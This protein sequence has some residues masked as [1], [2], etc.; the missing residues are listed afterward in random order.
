VIKYDIEEKKRIRRD[1]SGKGKK[2]FTAIQSSK[3]YLE[4]IKKAALSRKEERGFHFVY[5]DKNEL[6]RN[7]V[8]KDVDLP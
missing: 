8:M 3:F 6:K 4:S 2:M 5:S 1:G 7:A